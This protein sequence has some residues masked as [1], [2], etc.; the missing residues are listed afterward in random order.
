MEFLV[1]TFQQISHCYTQRSGDLS[2][3]DAAQCRAGC[4]PLRDS[5]ARNADTPRQLYLSEPDALAPVPDTSRNL[6]GQRPLFRFRRAG[7]T[8]HNS[9]A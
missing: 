5:T 2:K 9:D 3:M 6:F 7:L 4:L 8:T 1:G